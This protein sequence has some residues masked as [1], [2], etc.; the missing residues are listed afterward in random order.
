MITADAAKEM[1]RNIRNAYPNEHDANRI[2][3]LAFGDKRLTTHDKN[4]QL[5]I[6]GRLVAI[7]N[8][9]VSA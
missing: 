5:A 6:W 9:E 3:N 4:V 8:R 2:M 7:L 1:A